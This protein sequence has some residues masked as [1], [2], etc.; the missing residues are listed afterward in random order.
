MLHV[1]CA[2]FHFSY[3]TVNYLK[4]GVNVR[5]IL[6]LLK[7]AASS[8]PSPTDIKGEKKD[9]KMQDELLCLCTILVPLAPVIVVLKNTPSCCPQKEKAPI[10]LGNN[11]AFPET[12][13]T[14]LVLDSF[15]IFSMCSRYKTMTD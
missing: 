6:Y 9:N 7:L 12:D 5:F 3:A 14:V 8:G 4:L 15:P 1:K 2:N 13:L 10:V 11:G